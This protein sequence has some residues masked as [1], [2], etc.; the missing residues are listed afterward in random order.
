MGPYCYSLHHDITETP[1]RC[2]ILTIIE[3]PGIFITLL[4]YSR[5]S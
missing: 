2:L 5:Q 4:D 1:W 3:Y